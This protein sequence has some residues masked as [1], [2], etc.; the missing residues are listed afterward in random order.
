M[1][2]NVLQKILTVYFLFLLCFWVILQ[3]LGT[4]ESVF[5]YLYSFAFSL[6]P[7]VGGLYALFSSRAWG[8]SSA[9]GRVVFFTGA[10]LFSWGSGSMVWSYYNFFLHI[11]APYPSVADVAF[12]LSL[13][14]WILG[15]INLSKATGAQFGLKTIG[16]K[17]SII[18]IPLIVI[19]LSYV[20]LVRVARGGVVTNSLDNHVKLFFDLAYPIGDVAVFTVAAVIFVLSM[21]YIGGIYK[22]AILSMII[23]FCAMYFADF[24][25]SYT[26]SAGTFYNGNYGDLIFTVTLFLIAYGL[27]RFHDM[28]GKKV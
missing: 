1:K 6:I 20:L 2:L 26:T 14:L 5:N 15:M 12:I 25:F 3:Y 27:F 13:P 17:L 10:G 8:S 7:L 18:F 9:V 23:G 22:S 19:L 11:P 28:T 24:I 16:G 21:N 4:K